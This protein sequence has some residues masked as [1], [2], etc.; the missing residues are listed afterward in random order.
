MLVLYGEFFMKGD[1]L[2]DHENDKEN[3]EDQENKKAKG[4][5]TA[6]NFFVETNRLEPRYR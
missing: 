3:L 6:V 5:L 4:A 1:D 2:L